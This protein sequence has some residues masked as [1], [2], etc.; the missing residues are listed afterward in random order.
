MTV[1]VGAELVDVLVWAGVVGVELVDVLVWAGVVDAAGV[2]VG[3]VVCGGCTAYMTLAKVTCDC[4]SDIQSHSKAIYPHPYRRGRG[5]PGH[6]ASDPVDLE[7]GYAVGPCPLEPP[8]GCRQR[9][10]A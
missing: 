9:G 4:S 5:S 8:L 1:A 2:V 3:V 7:I 6:G 10:R